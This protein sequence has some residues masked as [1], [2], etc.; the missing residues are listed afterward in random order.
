MSSGFKE[1]LKQLWGDY[2]EIVNFSLESLLGDG[3]AKKVGKNQ[4]V[5]L[6]IENFALFMIYYHLFNQVLHS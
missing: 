6:K 3:F 4:K 1:E 5:R 2:T